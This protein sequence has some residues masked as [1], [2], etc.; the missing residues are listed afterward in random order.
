MPKPS[1]AITPPPHPAQQA[2]DWRRAQAGSARRGMTKSP[3]PPQPA[4]KMKP[5]SAAMASAAYWPTWNVW[6]RTE[7]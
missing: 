6:E 5:K 4:K 2:L 1:A 3:A 7:V